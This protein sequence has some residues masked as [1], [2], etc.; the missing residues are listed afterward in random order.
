[1]INLPGYFT[2][3]SSRTDGSYSLRFATQELSDEDVT[4]LSKHRNQ[5]GVVAFVE[6]EAQ[7]SDIP[8]GDAEEGKTP[9]QRLRA[10]LFVL[11]TQEGKKGEFESFY[12]DK[13]EKLI[14]HIKS[15]LT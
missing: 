13:M 9:S 5:F 1:M 14:D 4:T 15:K 6:N 8:K 10:S 7:L 2:G 11:W 3:F 12:R